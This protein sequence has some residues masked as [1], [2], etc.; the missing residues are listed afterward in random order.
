MPI[1]QYVFLFL[2][3]LVLAFGVLFAVSPLTD[4][5]AARVFSWLPSHLLPNV[6]PVYPEPARTAVLL[7]LVTGLVVDGIINPVVEELYF[8][9]YLLPRISRLGWL[10]PLVGAS[11]FTL[12]HFW[13]PYNYP[14]I[15]L[16]QLPLVYIVYWKRNIFIAILTHC[17][18]NMIGALLSLIS[19]LGSEHD[20]RARS[21]GCRVIGCADNGCPR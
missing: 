20:P 10:S 21:R 15:F 4:F 3:L 14:I 16:I 13:Q 19:F 11:L 8:R 5:L 7:V 9:G 6:E 18:G 1:W 17:A 12:A 2:L